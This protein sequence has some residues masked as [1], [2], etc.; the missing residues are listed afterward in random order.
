MICYQ[1]SILYE[2]YFI[3][4]LRSRYGRR[5]IWTDEGIWYPEVCRWLGMEHHVYPIGWKNFMERLNETFKDRVECFDDYFPCWKEECNRRHVFLW[6]KMFYF[7]YNFVREHSELG[8]PPALYDS[9]PER[10]V[11]GRPLYLAGPGGD[12]IGAKLT[13]PIYDCKNRSNNFPSAGDRRAITQYVQHAKR[14]IEE[15]IGI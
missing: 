6:I 9:P 3:R 2:Y 11:R 15:R 8:F 7:Y 14:R 12:P 4:H 10:Q 13:A 5:P 1:R